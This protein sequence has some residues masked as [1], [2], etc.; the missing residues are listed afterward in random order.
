[1]AY[2]TLLMDADETLLDFRKSEGFALEATLREHGIAMT[3]AVHD[4]Y[5]EINRVLWQQLERGEIERARLKEQRFEEL[6]VWLGAEGIDAAAFNASYMQTLGTKGFLLEGALDLLKDLSEKYAVYIITNGSASV[7]HVRLADS[8]I[9]PYVRGVF[10]SEEVG[11]DK[12]SVGFFDPVWHAIGAP[13]K[14]ELLIIGD[15]LTSDIRGGINAGID[16][17]WYNPDGAAH[18][19]DIVPTATVH[20]YQELRQFL[21]NK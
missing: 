17:C 16:T 14:R 1:M 2:T 7:Q 9:L 19:A 21:Q 8:G 3:P 10:I 20:S 15:S 6:F 11:A 13:D 5:H 12:P 18:P 4:R